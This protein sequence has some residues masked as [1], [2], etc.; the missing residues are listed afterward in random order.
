[1]NAAAPLITYLNR[2]ERRWRAGQALLWLPRLLVLG[3]L[4]V[5]TGLW[6]ALALGW[7]PLL[8]G[9][10]ALAAAAAAGLGWGLWRLRRPLE[11]AACYYDRAWQLQERLATALDLTSGRIPDGPLAAYQLEDALNIASTI[12]ARKQLPLRWRWPEWLAAA[13]LCG[14][15]LASAALAANWQGTPAAMSEATRASVETAAADLRDIIQDIASDTTLET[16]TRAALLADL[17]ASLNTLAQPE[18]TTEQAFAAISE[19]RDALQAAA[20]ALAQQQQAQQAALAAAAEAFT[21]P[22][23]STLAEALE[24]SAQ[25]AP[26]ASAPQNA[27]QAQA[28]ERAAAML[29]QQHPELAEAMQQAAD[30]LRQPGGQQAQQALEQAAQ[31]A[32]DAQQRAQDAQQRGDNLQQAADAMQH[33]AQQL[34]QSEQAQSDHNAQ[35]QPQPPSQSGQ[36]AAQ[37]QQNTGDTSQAQPPQGHSNQSSQSPGDNQQANAQA[38]TMSQPGDG[39]P[40]SASVQQGDPS[41]SQGQQQDVGAAEASGDQPS[42]AT[43]PQSESAGSRQSTTD[44]DGTGERA[45]EPIYAPLGAVSQGENDVTLEGDASQAPVRPGETLTLPQQN[46]SI[47]YN[48]VYSLYTQQL[49]RALESDV[50]PAGLKD[51]IRDYF[52]TIS[53]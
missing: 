25:A 5:I 28:L 39:A 52:N 41:S 48:E 30:A 6:G 18:L 9:A 7:P 45:F 27:Q 14:L 3:A 12:D 53:P 44:N 1:M 49:G 23:S 13:L 33:N 11:Q 38:N 24:E 22:Q 47:P 43:N 2:W 36:Q 40:Q 32:S 15:A 34:A 31:Q 21:G 20:A 4:A 19:S 37:N 42:E 51:V 35:R 29:A 17:Q 16:E 10:A 8:V 26:T 50:V 46:A